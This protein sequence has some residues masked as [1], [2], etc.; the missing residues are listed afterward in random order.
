[1]IKI[2]KIKSCEISVFISLSRGLGFIFLYNFVRYLTV[3]MSKE[4]IDSSLYCLNLLRLLVGNIKSEILLHSNNKLDWVQ[5]VESE[6]LK[7]C[8]SVELLLI[9]L[10]STSE[11]LED[12]SFNFLHEG[13]LAGVGSGCELVV[14]F[15]MD[16]GWLLKEGG[17]GLFTESKLGDAEDVF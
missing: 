11:D 9:A 7:G 16:G 1:M 17:N 4:C 2:K 14:N 10:G 13:D 8:S 12:L 15:E 6:L 5:W 3:Q